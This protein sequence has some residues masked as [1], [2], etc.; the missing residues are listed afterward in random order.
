V[1]GMRPPFCV[2]WTLIRGVPGLSFVSVL[3]RRRPNEMEN[4]QMPPMMAMSVALA[5]SA[6]LA[7]RDLVWRPPVMTIL[8]RPPVE[9]SAL[10]SVQHMMLAERSPAFPHNTVAEQ[11]RGRFVACER[12]GAVSAARDGNPGAAARDGHAGCAGDVGGACDAGSGAAAAGDDDL[13][14]AAGRDLFYWRQSRTL[15]SPGWRPPFLI[16]WSLSR[17]V[18]NLSLVSVWQRRRPQETENL[19]PPLVMAI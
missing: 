15:C 6:G 11:R 1:P 12:M 18:A 5:S 9:T 19:G 10:S 17:G 14:A 2:I 4:L 13:T 3:Q 7:M 8:R 16:L